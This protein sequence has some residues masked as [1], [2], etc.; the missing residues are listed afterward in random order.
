MCAMTNFAVNYVPDGTYMTLPDS[1]MTA[2]E[3]GLSLQEMDP[4]LDSD[5]GTGNEIGY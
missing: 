4:I 1:S 5:Y 2:Y 3:I